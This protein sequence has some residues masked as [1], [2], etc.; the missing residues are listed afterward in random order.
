MSNNKDIMNY[1]LLP[2]STVI[3]LAVVIPL[4][5]IIVVIVI[6]V[7]IKRFA[8]NLFSCSDPLLLLDPGDGQIMLH[9]YDTHV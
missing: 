6:V 1:L 9:L 4:V 7:Y 5:V 2:D 8:F 3:A